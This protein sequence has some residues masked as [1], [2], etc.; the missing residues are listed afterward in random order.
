MRPYVDEETCIGCGACEAIC[1]A[2]PVVFKV[3]DTSKVV[4]PDACIECEECVENCPVDA[5]ELDD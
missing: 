4:N 3:E 5:I 2:D 1:P